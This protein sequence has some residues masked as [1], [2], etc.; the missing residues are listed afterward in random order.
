MNFRTA[1]EITPA[2]WRITHQHIG[3]A[4]GSCFA[5]SITQAMSRLKYNIS[6][7][8]FGA[9]YNPAS[10]AKCIKR[11]ASAQPY[12]IDELTEWQGRW[13]SMDAHTLFDASSAEEALARLN[14][15]L[16][17]AH[18]TLTQSDY[19]IITLGTNYVYEQNGTIVTNCHKLPAA[20]FSRRKMELQEMY[21]TLGEVLN[22]ELKGK[23]IIITVSPIRHIKDGLTESSLSKA[24]LRIVASQLSEGR[25]IHYFP[26]YEIMTDDLRD[27]RFY[28]PDMIHPSEV[29][30]SYI[31]E[32]FNESWI[33]PSEQELNRRIERFVKGCEHRPFDTQSEAFLS[34]I[35]AQKKVC[36]TLKK[37]CPNGNFTKEEIFLD[38][39]SRIR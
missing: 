22:N 19:I 14:D 23:Q 13:F 26:S 15:T 31:W 30:V 1:I 5:E 17:Q 21:D 34:F 4:F 3:M 32:R 27:Y 29:A 38:D 36:D 28:A 35:N 9:L 2:P 7:N 8:P 24:A 20:Q 10:V 39:M 25:N 18:N 33:E 16:D 12:S 11:I 6:C 37:E